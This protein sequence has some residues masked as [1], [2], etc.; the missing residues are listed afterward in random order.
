MED[1]LKGENVFYYDASP[2]LNNFATPGSDFA[3]EVVTKNP[4]LR[5]KLASAD[6]TSTETVV[7]VDGFAFAPADRLCVTEGALAA[8]KPQVTD[9]NIT[10]YTLKPT[11]NRVDNADYYEIAFYQTACYRSCGQFRFGQRTLCI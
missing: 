4:Q 10:A 8:P 5:V 2:N 1:F 11:W 7:N 9:E 3:R 6:I